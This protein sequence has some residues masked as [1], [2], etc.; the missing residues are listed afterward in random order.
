MISIMRV[1]FNA[2]FSSLAER[3]GRGAVCGRGS[4][5]RACDLALAVFDCSSNSRRQRRQI[6]AHSFASIR[7]L[8]PERLPRFTRCHLRVTFLACFAQHLPSN[9]IPWPRR[10]RNITPP[11]P[12]AILR[13]W[14]ISDTVTVFTSVP[15]T[16]MCS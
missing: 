11:S 8:L 12:R 15:L 3:R 13:P 2:G 14:S 5:G 7:A 10:E 6:T 1:D 4:N 9:N 16:R